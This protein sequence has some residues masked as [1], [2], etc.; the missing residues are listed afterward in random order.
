MKMICI[1]S[2]HA[3]YASVHRSEKKT[4]LPQT[5]ACFVYY[6]LQHLFTRHSYALIGS[7]TH[8]VVSVHSK[9]AGASCRLPDEIHSIHLYGMRGS[10]LVYLFTCKRKS[11]N[12][13]EHK[14]MKFAYTEH[15]E[16]NSCSQNNKDG[17]W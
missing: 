2:S 13:V 14:C 10:S 12:R 16:Q 11:M 1:S 8:W 17:I 4:L 3:R 9:T 5:T 7:L 15:Q 6:A